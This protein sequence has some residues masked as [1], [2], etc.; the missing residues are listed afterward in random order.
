MLSGS[1]DL[2][3]E[4]R[5]FRLNN[6]INPALL[7]ASLLFEGFCKLLFLTTFPPSKHPKRRYE[8]GTPSFVRS[9]IIVVD[10]LQLA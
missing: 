5:Y 8:G 3:E 4:E 9:V 10:G 7:T 2:S 6:E 1:I